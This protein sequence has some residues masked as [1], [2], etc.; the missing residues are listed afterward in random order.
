MHAPTSAN[1]ALKMFQQAFQKDDLKQSPD[2][3]IEFEKEAYKGGRTEPFIKEFKS[4]GKKELYYYDINS[5]YPS[6]MTELM[7]SRYKMCVDMDVTRKVK[8]DE[9]VDYNIYVCRSEYANNNKRIIPNLLTRTKKGNIIATKNTK[10]SSHWGKEIKEAIKN[11]FDIYCKK[12]IVYEGKKIFD[13]FANY[14]YTKRLEVKYTNNALSLFYK[15]VMN[16]L[17]GKFGQRSFNKTKLISDIHDLNGILNSDMTKLIN[18]KVVGNIKLIEYKTCEQ[19]YTSI[20]KLMRFASYISSTSRCK[21]SEFMRD[22][23]HENVYYCDTDSVFTSNKPSAHFI[24]QNILG[25]WKLE[26]KPIKRAVFL[27]PKMYCYE[28]IDGKNDKKAK[29]INKNNMLKLNDYETMLQDENTKISRKSK[30]FF[31]TLEN[32]KIEDQIRRVTPVFNKR[33]WK[34]TTSY[35]YNK[36]EDWNKDILRASKKKK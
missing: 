7:P 31:R 14:F 25:K 3:I 12:A 9:I 8:L 20:G 16:S 5:S 4:D 36:I 19:E 18:L 11:G 21:L 23:G 32:I 24:D 29:G 6:G 15:T 22:V 28:T 26:S 35:P 2:N 13:V 27:A 1:L 17:Y 33:I 10:F 30:M 34:G